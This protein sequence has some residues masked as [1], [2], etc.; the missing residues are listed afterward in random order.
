MSVKE[1]GQVERSTRGF[2]PEVDSLMQKTDASIVD[3]VVA[4]GWEDQH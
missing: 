4:E 1:I 3:S 2:Y